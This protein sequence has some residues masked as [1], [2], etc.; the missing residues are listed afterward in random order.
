MGGLGMP[1]M[2]VILLIVLILFGPSKLPVL[3]EGLGKAIGGFKKGL[4]DDQ[5]GNRESTKLPS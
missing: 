3:G 1:E 5:S 2:I 4:R